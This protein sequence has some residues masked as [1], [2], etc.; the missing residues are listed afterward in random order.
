MTKQ[1]Q[2]F[3]LLLPEQLICG[4]GQNKGAPFTY[5]SPGSYLTHAEMGQNHSEGK[6]LEKN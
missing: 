4:S 3:P 1:V 5:N 2:S 6:K